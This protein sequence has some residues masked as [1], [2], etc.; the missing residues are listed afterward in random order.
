MKLM[1]EIEEPRLNNLQ[2]RVRVR[3]GLEIG[4]N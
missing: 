1:I 4:I 2:V 3:L